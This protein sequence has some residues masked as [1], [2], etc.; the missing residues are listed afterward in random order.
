M[1][2]YVIGT[3]DTKGRELAYVKGLVEAR[4]VPAVLVDVGTGPDSPGQDIP[5]DVTAR[6][7]A[8]HH[9]GGIDAVFSDDRGRASG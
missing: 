6:E 9:P 7:V 5:L 1:K 3:C 4:G 2:A 8:L